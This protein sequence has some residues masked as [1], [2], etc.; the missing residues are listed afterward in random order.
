MPPPNR[1]RPA[2]RA[3]DARNRLRRGKPKVCFFCASHAE[4]VDYKDVNVLRRFVSDRGKVKS[5]G[6][7]GTC[8]QHQRAVATAIKTAREL[9]LLP[10][11]VRTFASDK[12]GGRGG[13]GAPRGGD[14]RPESTESA[15]ATDATESSDATESAARAGADVVTTGED[16]NRSDQLESEV[17]AGDAAE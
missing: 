16:R 7:T 14:R 2:P 15:D 5:R 13:R 12:A 10:Y 3:A 11:V 17:T 6:N 9:A 4:W 8:V 1:K